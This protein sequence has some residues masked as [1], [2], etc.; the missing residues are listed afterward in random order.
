MNEQW[1]EVYS[2]TGDGEAQSGSL[3]ALTQAFEVGREFKVGIRDLCADVTGATETV[4]HEVFIQCGPGYY[5][6]KSRRFIAG[7]NPL[8]RVKPAIPLRYHSQEWDF[9][10]LMVRTDGHVARWIVD[11]YTLKFNRSAKRYALRWFVR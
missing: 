3:D 5:S 6:T 11:P 4:P 8:V 10:W 2:H 9:G 1:R 7:T